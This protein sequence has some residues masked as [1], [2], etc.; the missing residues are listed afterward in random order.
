MN[1]GPSYQKAVSLRTSKVVYCRQFGNAKSDWEVI[2][3]EAGEVK[4]FGSA[5]F[6]AMFVP[7][8]Q[9]PSHMRRIAQA[10]PSWWDWKAARGQV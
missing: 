8:W 6:K 4:V 10:A 2:D 3:S 9:L 5:Q 1:S 7:D